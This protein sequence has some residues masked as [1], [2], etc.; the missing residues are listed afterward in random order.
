MTEPV[1]QTASPRPTSPEASFREDVNGLRA[2]AV[3]GVL[4]FHYDAP[5][6]SGGYAGVDVFF[7]ISGYLMT[8][9]IATRM[10][11]GSFSL[12]RFWGDRALRIAPPL[13]FMLA[14]LL[15]F[16]LFWI[17]ALTLA[18]I[19]D[20]ALRAAGFV[21]NIHFWRSVGYF[22][23]RADQKWLLHTWSLGVEWQ[24]YLVF[25]FLMLALYRQPASA[26]SR[27]LVVLLVACASFL[28]AVVLDRHHPVTLFYL[29]PFRAWELLAGCLVA[30]AAPSLAL[31]AKG[32]SRLALAGLAAIVAAFILFDRQSAWP[33]WGTLLPVAGASAVIL[34]AA[35]RPAWA[36]NPPVRALGLWSYSIYLWHWPFL[37]LWT[38]S[39]LE[40]ALAAPAFAVF[41]LA[42]AG[43]VSLAGQWFAAR[44]PAAR[45]GQLAVT[46]AGWTAAAG[47]AGA[48]ALDGGAPWRHPSGAPW[49]ENLREASRDWR[50]PSNCNA[51]QKDGAPKICGFNLDAAGPPVVFLGDSHSAL[52]Y[53]RFLGRAR[54]ASQA[55][56]HF[57]TAAACPPLPDVN[58]VG[59][60]VRCSAFYEAAIR[61]LEAQ[62][63]RRLVITS[64]W[65]TYAR[66]DG[67]D[68][69]CFMRGDRCVAPETQAELSNGLRAAFVRSAPALQRLQRSGVEIVIMLPIPIHDESIPLALA[70]DDIH[71]RP[72]SAALGIDLAGFRSHNA[73]IIGMLKAY[74]ASLGAAVIDPTEPMCA[75][76]SCST[77]DAAQVPLYVDSNH[78]TGAAL[79]TERFGFIDALVE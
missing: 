4:L 3:L 66:L 19:A 51:L 53:S 27:G 78:L 69:I 6:L 79:R 44:G 38:Y 25:P 72:R 2:L 50:F 20:E 57:L 59:N 22:D 31:G 42:G 61:H 74:A 48:L 1:P 30:I 24:F 11:R 5:Y 56:V 75:N 40:G 16:G 77:V 37:V 58:R 9:I 29:L 45:K 49:V 55:P 65:T 17:D 68:S 23:L 71:G 54:E 47:L 18:E 7:V 39:G 35:D 34:A 73:E 76:G 62:P 46:F 8:R 21:S 36:A 41:F 60:H 67:P 52:W 70:R 13:A 28:P 26:L 32:R 33:S 15:V 64:I 10:E 43:L 12:W 63:P 14:A